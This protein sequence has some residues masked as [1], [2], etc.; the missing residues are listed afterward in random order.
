MKKS[1]Q[2]QPTTT[3]WASLKQNSF[4]EAQTKTHKKNQVKKAPTQSNKHTHSKETTKRRPDSQI[5]RQVSQKLT[6]QIKPKT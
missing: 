3:K 4:A 2:A 6:N 5:S 1:N